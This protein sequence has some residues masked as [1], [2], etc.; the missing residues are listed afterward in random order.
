MSV[1]VKNANP[2][3]LIDRIAV[4]LT[5]FTGGNVSSTRAVRLAKTLHAIKQAPADVER[6]LQQKNTKHPELNINLLIAQGFVRKSDTIVQDGITAEEKRIKEQ[7]ALIDNFSRRVGQVVNQLFHSNHDLHF[8]AKTILTMEKVYGITFQTNARLR[9]EI[10]HP[11]WVM[12]EAQAELNTVREKL[13]KRPSEKLERKERELCKTIDKNAKII[14][15]K[16]EKIAEN[17]AKIISVVVEVSRANKN[18]IPK[19]CK[20]LLNIYDKMEN[21]AAMAPAMIDIADKNIAQLQEMHS[22]ITEYAGRLEHLHFLREVAATMKLANTVL[23]SEHNSQEDLRKDI[24]D[25]MH[26][27]ETINNVVSGKKID[28]ASP[29]LAEDKPLKLPDVPKHTP[30]IKTAIAN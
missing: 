23:Q 20:E 12:S 24:V 6:A 17:R 2:I 4:K 28:R 14:A 13:E 22:S 26:V 5:K 27:E 8:R 16:L 1:S 19:E 15:S 3:S 29:M 18:N 7:V 21:D 11:K 30:G 9:D 25:T 10:K